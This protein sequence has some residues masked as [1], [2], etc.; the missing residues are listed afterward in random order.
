MLGSQ[1]RPW[2]TVDCVVFDPTGAVLVIKRGKTPFVDKYA[3]PGGFV[4]AGE[5]AEAAAFREL[6]EETGLV[7]KTAKL[8]N[9]FSEPG[10]DPRHHVISLAYLIETEPG[11]PVAGDDAAWAE[12]R[13]DWRALEFAFD[14]AEIVAQAA[15]LRAT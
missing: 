8:V 10:R 7:G 6:R 4:E 3:L 13:S 5:S 2:V 14:H 12:F 1:Q 15:R 9:V 11:T